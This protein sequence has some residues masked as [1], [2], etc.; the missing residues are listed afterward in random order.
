MNNIVKNTLNKSFLIT[1][2]VF[3]TL[4]FSQ[5]ATANSSIPTT[6]ATSKIGFCGWNFDRWLDW[7]RDSLL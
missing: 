7:F 6:V 4:T 1:G 3:S 2:L 5:T